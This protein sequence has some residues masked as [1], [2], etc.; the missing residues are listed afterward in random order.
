MPFDGYF[1]AEARTARSE[2]QVLHKPQEDE[3]QFL[4]LGE[5]LNLRKKLH[6]TSVLERVDQLRAQGPAPAPWVVELDPTTA[7]N[8]ACPDCIS[9]DLLNQGG[10]ERERLRDLA[11]EMV[12]AGV[13]AVVLIGGGEPLAHP[14]AEWVIR[15][16]GENGLQIGVTTN[17]TLI[18]RHMDCLAEHA[19]WVRVSVD[20]ASSETFQHFRPS[21]KGVSEFDNVIDNMR[22]FAR[23]KRGKLGYS[24]LMLTE[25]DREG[26][27]LRSNIPEIYTGA[28]LAR[29][30]G[31]DY[32]EVKP[33]FDFNHFLI[34]QPDAL[35]NQAKEQINAIEH[36]QT[37]SFKSLTATKTRFVL[38]NDVQ[39]QPKDYHDCTVAK[40]RTLLTP[41]GAYV[42]PYFRGVAAKQIGDVTK[43]SFT[44][45]W[46][47]AQRAA[48]M[49]KLD[50]SK[51]CRFHCIRHES[52][53]M[54]E[55]ILKS[56]PEEGG[57]DYD[58][59]I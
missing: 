24:F 9:R 5:E 2:G 50:P 56:P 25:C 44:E 39:S 48:V 7:C 55:E 52:N 34:G 19:S 30:I 23:R 36:L 27:V 51:D 35:L 6:Q 29:D 58:F 26:N 11:R 10:F 13:R 33:S 42:C 54:L 14:E 32:F 1:G 3:E 20:A 40:L 16:F 47:G 21:P 37:E 22:A 12:D 49:D 17:G 43:Q 59:F 38:E 18:D 57:P 45:M 28:L 46:H 15:H 41:S 4:N 53:L 31:C 8:L